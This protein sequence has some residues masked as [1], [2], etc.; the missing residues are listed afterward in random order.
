MRVK[1]IKSLIADKI[2]LYDADGLE[3]LWTGKREN[4]PSQYICAEIKVVGAERKGTIG[5]GIGLP[6]N[7]KKGNK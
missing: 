2:C 6:A 7:P 5:I 3:T 4:M 1:D